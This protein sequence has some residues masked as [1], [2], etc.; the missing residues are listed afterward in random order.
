MAS[1]SAKNY[2]IEWVAITHTLNLAFNDTNY[3]SAGVTDRSFSDGVSELPNPALNEIYPMDSTDTR[4][5]IYYE[6]QVST[7]SYYSLRFCSK[8]RWK[9]L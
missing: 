4:K 8:T 7:G 2:S 5:T 3:I 6:I 9:V 1:L